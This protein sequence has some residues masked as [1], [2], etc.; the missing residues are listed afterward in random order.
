MHR[1][2][3]FSALLLRMINVGEQS[4]NFD[5]A[6]DNVSVY[7]N[8]VIPRRIKALFTVLEPAMMLGLIF[9]VGA[10]AIAI[11]SPIMSLMGG[12]QNR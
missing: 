7:Y 4:G 6:L 3:I 1:Q 5:Q 11:Y 12:L 9:I 2:P 8:Q 10:V